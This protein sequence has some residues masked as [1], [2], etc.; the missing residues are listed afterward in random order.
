MRLR[1]GGTKGEKRTGLNGRVEGLLARATSGVEVGQ[2]ADADGTLT[3]TL[4]LVV[5]GRAVVHGAVVPDLRGVR[6]ES[7]RVRKGEKKEDVRRGR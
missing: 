3:G 2:L 1:K 7:V 4:L 5:P 6:K